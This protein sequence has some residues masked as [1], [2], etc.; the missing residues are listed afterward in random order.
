MRPLSPLP[1]KPDAGGGTAGAPVVVEDSHLPVPP[2]PLLPPL[3]PRPPLALPHCLPPPVR[4]M[5]PVCP[6]AP[7][8]SHAWM[9]LPL[10]QAWSQQLPRDDYPHFP[11]FNRR[12]IGWPPDITVEVE[13]PPWLA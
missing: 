6:V 13:R 3:P 4:Q 8:T 2:L 10:G 7:H 11:R 9:R 5:G 12:H 1:V